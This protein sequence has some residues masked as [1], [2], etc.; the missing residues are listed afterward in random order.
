MHELLLTSTRK[1]DEL[2][3]GWHVWETYGP[4]EMSGVLGFICKAY[5]DPGVE[6]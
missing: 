5:F 1:A 2:E 3:S 6:N 4:C